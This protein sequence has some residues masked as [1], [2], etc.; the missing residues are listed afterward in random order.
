MPQTEAFAPASLHDTQ[1][2][3]GGLMTVLG[4]HLYSTPLVALRE[5]VQNAH[6][7]LVRRRMEDPA[8]EG[9]G[10]I[11]VEGDLGA[12]TLRIR[13]TGA[14]LTPAEIH[15]CLATVGVGYTRR[16]REETG[17]DELI[18]LFGLGFLSAFVLA[19]SVT[20]TTT[21][22]QTPGDTWAYH[23]TSGERYR[24][25][26]ATPTGVPGTVVELKLREA[27]RTLAGTGAQ[28]R[29]LQRYCAL[30]RAPLYLADETEPLNALQPPWRPGALLEHPAQARRTRLAFARQFEPHYEPLCTLPLAPRGD[31]DARGL[32]W[33][34]DGGSY[35]T[36]DNRHLSVFVRGMLL[37]DEARD[38]LP[39]WAGF[40]GGVLESSALTP[41]ASR[42]DLQKDGTYRAVQEALRE[43]LVEGLAALAQEDP[44]AWRRVLRRHN[45]ALLGAA[46]CDDRLFEL[47]AEE[48][49]VPTT[50]GE[51]PVRALRVRGDVH[52]TLGQGGFEEMRFRALQI[53]LARGDRYAVVPFLRTWCERRGGRLVEVGT[54]QGNGALFTP[55]ALEPE[56]AAWLETHLCHG[57]RLVGARFTPAELP[58]LVVPDHEAQLKARLEADEADSRISGAALRLARAFTGKVEGTHPARLFLN[59]DSPVVQAM[60]DAREAGHPAAEDTARTLW[61]LKVL[62]AQ[63]QDTADSDLGRALARLQTTLLRT[64]PTSKGTP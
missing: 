63:G 49:E 36:S 40:V 8:F 45:E 53:P 13:D 16:L 38:L 25:L 50:A 52:V 33:I 31:S 3:L 30:L 37:D 28:R 47:L 24:V 12:G 11:T 32:L 7:S 15:S 35:A 42:E 27:H 14:G 57:E 44:A 2:D 58:L 46:L 62:L 39:P 51:R 22:Y 59:L 41:T 6:D 48:L 43:A 4:Q 10:R 1:V 21:S 64:L 60:L 54:V 26:P 61:A 23:A 17:S 34:Q 56:E 19:E 9:P 20:V 5:L 29:V 18:G 55:V